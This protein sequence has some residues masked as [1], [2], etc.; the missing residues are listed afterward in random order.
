MIQKI[1]E[2]LLWSQIVA[3][4]WCDEGF[5]K[6]LLSD[7]RDVLAEHGMGVPED[8]E[9]KVVEGTEV[10]VEDTDRERH[11]IL[12]VSPPDELTDEDLV[13][14]AAAWCYSGVCGACGRCGCRCRCYC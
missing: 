10:K 11:F 13:G 5:M 7:P 6:R 9:V 8:R 14:G 4:A 3:K 2:D 1:S 12:S